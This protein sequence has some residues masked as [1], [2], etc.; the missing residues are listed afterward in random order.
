[1]GHRALVAYRRPGRLYDLRYS[2]WGGSDLSLPEALTAETPLAD[3]RVEA[4]PLAVDVSLERVL[5]AFLDPC[6]YEALF[7]VPESFAVTAYRVPW[8][9]WADGRQRGRGA[10][11]PV[12][13][14]APDLRFR[15]WFRATRTAMG[16]AVEMGVLSRDAA[17]SYLESRVVEDEG[18][19]VY[20]HTGPTRGD[21]EDGSLRG[22]PEGGSF[23]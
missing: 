18:G 12:D 7:L 3:G 4:D 2:H 16:D 21:P 6:V 10:I 9:E 15:T 5:E 17:R 23:E 13:P 19:Y 20:T 14:G 8:L 22:D 1:M 11:V